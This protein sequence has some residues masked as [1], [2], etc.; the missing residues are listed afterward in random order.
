MLKVALTGGIGCG[1]TTVAELFAA[2]Q[3]P[4]IDADE[5]GRQLV[6][7]GQ[8]GLSLISETLGEEFVTEAG[9]LDRKKLRQHIFANVDAKQK[10]E[11]ILHPRIYQ[12]IALQ[13][14]TLQA[15][16][17][18]IC[19]PLLFETQMEKIADR[20]LV[21][22]CPLEQQIRR[23]VS[24]DH[25]SEASALAIINNQIAR[26]IRLS[27]A[28]DVINNAGTATSLSQQVAALHHLYVSLNH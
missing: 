23:V 5:V 21:V 16:Y 10:L 14:A 12:A 28:D 19:V 7:P 27:K 20:V 4:I 17:C 24:R 13:I 6:E 11:A 9:V 25:L 1:K 8:P 18:I 22:D 26:E 15:A 2:Y 3:V